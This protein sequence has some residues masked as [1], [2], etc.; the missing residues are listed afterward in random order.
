MWDHAGD[1]INIIVLSF[2]IGASNWWP[3]QYPPSLITHALRGCSWKDQ[4]HM[5]DECK[6][7]QI[8]T[9]GPDTG[10]SALPLARSTCKFLASAWKSWHRPLSRWYSTRLQPEYLSDKR[11]KLQHGLPCLK[12]NLA[13][14]TRKLRHL[15]R[16]WERISIPDF[17]VALVHQHDL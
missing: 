12:S 13:S 5:I 9:H 8:L 7:I 15:G 1:R 14:Q 11:S 6:V 16:Q 2:G 3:I 4:A 10:R 17:L